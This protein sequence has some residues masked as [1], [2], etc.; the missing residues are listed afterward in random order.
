VDPPVL[1]ARGRLTVVC[2]AHQRD[3]SLKA[4][5]LPPAVADLVEVAPAERLAAAFPG[6]RTE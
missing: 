4:A 2:V 5:H 6:P 3:G 1:V